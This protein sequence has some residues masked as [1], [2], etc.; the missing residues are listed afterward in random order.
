M[1]L[2]GLEISHVKQNFC[3]TEECLIV[4]RI[5]AQTLLIALKGSVIVFLNVLHLA[6][7]EIESGSQVLDVLSVSWQVTTLRP[8]LVLDDSETGIA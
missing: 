7:D 6:Q 2:C 8:C 3:Q 1:S 5:V 4:A